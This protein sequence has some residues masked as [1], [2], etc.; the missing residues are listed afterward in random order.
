MKT[1]TSS[2]NSKCQNCGKVYPDNH[3]GIIADLGQ[4]VSSGEPMPSGECPNCGALCQPVVP[5]KI[6]YIS[7]EK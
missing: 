3:L 1:E 2:D 4:R 5:P 6:R 7:E